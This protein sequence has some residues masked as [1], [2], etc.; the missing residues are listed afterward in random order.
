MKRRTFLASLAGLL[1]F[2]GKLSAVSTSTGSS[3]YHYTYCYYYD[4]NRDLVTFVDGVTT[5]T[6][7]GQ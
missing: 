3:G 5:V 6:R 7:C 2:N 4:A 1:A